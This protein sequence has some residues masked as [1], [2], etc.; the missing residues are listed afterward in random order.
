M[1]HNKKWC[2]GS[3]MYD[4]AYSGSQN[5]PNVSVLYPSPH[6]LSRSEWILPNSKQIPTQI[7]MGEQYF[8][9]DNDPK[10]ISKKATQLFQDNNIQL[11]L[12][13]AQ[14]PDLNH[15]E[16]LWKHVKWPF[17]KYNISPKGV[18]KLWDRLVNEWNCT[19]SMSKLHIKYAQMHTGSYQDNVQW[20]TKLSQCL[21][22]LDR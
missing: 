18:Y 19:R 20:L 22:I 7:V 6:V 4:S 17:S 15:I 21:I 14:F 16:H 2:D 3:C 5:C 9:Q 1:S 13:P 12:W 11:L 8:Q 10:H